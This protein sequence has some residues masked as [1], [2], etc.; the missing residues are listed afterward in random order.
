MTGPEGLAGLADLAAGRPDLSRHRVVCLPDLFVDHLVDVADLDAFAEAIQG[1]ARRGG[2]NV[3]GGPQRLAPG[4]QAANVARHLAGLGVEVALHAPTGPM[5]R[6]V[7]NYWLGSLDV[8]LDGLVE[9]ET[10]LT[11]ALEGPDTNVMVND[12]A[13]LMDL[14]F[15]EIGASALDGADRCVMANWAQMQD[16]DAFVADLLAAALDREVPVLVDPGDPRPLERDHDLPDVLARD[17]PWIV[18]VN[19]HEA[20]ALDLPGQAPY[21]VVVHTAEAA[22]LHRPGAEPVEV[23]SF[24]VTPRRRTGAGDAFNAGLVAGDLLGLDDDRMLAL[25]H[26]VAGAAVTSDRFVV[27]WGDVERVVEA[28]RG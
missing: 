3:H 23:P 6:L 15:D 19:E 14:P 9:A 10:S 8:D 26:A 20:A 17:P 16:G 5:G 4:G 25:A 12:A 18:S 7:A 2:G 1:T 28:G 24:D 13:A 22:R 11:V 27:G 21:P